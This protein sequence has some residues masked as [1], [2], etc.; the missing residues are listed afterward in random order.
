[1]EGDKRDPPSSSH[2]E[3]IYASVNVC[4]VWCSSRQRSGHCCVFY[5]SIC[6]C[7]EGQNRLW[8]LI[9]SFDLSASASW[10][11]DSHRTWNS[12]LHLPFNLVH[13]MWRIKIGFDC[14]RRWKYRWLG[15]LAK[16]NGLPHSEH[17]H[18]KK[19][20]PD[21]CYVRLA[22]CCCIDPWQLLY[23]KSFCSMITEFDFLPPL[24][25]WRVPARLVTWTF[26]SV[27]CK[28]PKF[29]VQRA[30][31]DDFILIRY[32]CLVLWTTYD[33]DFGNFDYVCIIMY[34]Y[35]CSHT[36]STCMYSVHVTYMYIV[37]W[38]RKTE[39]QLMP[40]LHVHNVMYMYMCVT[41]ML[42]VYN[43]IRHFGSD[44][45]CDHHILWSNIKLHKY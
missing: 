10:A 45:T 28:I 43:Y 9:W 25:V 36:C 22:V 20:T 44:P 42:H 19:K 3:Y 23:P 34:M 38:K 32:L 40:I 15:N 24:P 31:S 5:T 8:K 29:P 16:R 37:L 17:A 11:I 2:C 27:I 7:E 6:C 26:T 33:G 14:C 35:I 30:H 18:C 1:M 21:R 12:W 13:V 41:C 4:Y 39:W